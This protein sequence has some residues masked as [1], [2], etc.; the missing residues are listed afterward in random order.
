MTILPGTM[1]S[2]VGTLFY[3]F[4]VQRS[5]TVYGL[6]V[7]VFFLSGIYLC[8]LAARS[9]GTADP[10]FIVWDEITGLLVAMAPAGR[11][12]RPMLAAFFYIPPARRREALP[13]RRR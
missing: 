2:V 9:H 10:A 6:T 4:L 5:K 11:E 13:N 3:W 7:L 1:G 8:G 12:W